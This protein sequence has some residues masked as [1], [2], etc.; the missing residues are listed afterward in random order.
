MKTRYIK[1]KNLSRRVQMK[2]LDQIPKG[3][4][5]V[6]CPWWPEDHWEKK[7]KGLPFED[8]FYRIVEKTS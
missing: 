1:F 8:C 5:E 7:D 6:N 3:N 2:I 4:V